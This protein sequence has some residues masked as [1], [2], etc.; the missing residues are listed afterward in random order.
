MPALQL[1]TS[2]LVQWRSAVVG[3]EP[4][5]VGFSPAVL[6]MRLRLFIIS[7][8]RSEIHPLIRFPIH[9]DQRIPL[10]TTDGQCY[11]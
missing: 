2:T 9:G 1:G 7:D 6:A 10:R 5:V 4:V 8:Y 3:H 11:T